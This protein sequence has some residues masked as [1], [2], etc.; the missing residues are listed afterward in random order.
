MIKP[1][2]NV[3]AFV[4]DIASV[5]TVPLT[6]TDSTVELMMVAVYVPSLLS[7][8]ELIVAFPSSTSATVWPPDVAF[9]PSPFTC[10]VIVE[11]DVPFASTESADATRVD[12]VWSTMVV[13]KLAVIAL[14]AVT[15]VMV[16]GLVVPVASPLQA[17]NA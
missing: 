5:L 14:S 1:E 7:V 16:S 11:V 15:L 17:V 10:T 12:A 6:V 8:T 3:I 13:W 9:T 4:L 2:V